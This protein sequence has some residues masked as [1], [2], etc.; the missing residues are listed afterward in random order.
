M[1]ILITGGTGLVGTR[2]TEILVKNG[3]RVSYLSRSTNTSS[4]I[5]I[6]KWDLD[7]N[8]IDPAAFE[9]IDCIVHLAGAGIADKR[10]SDDRKKEILESRIKPIEL[11]ANY[12]KN[13]SHTIKS[14]ISA[15]AIG[16]YGGDTG[17]TRIDETSAAGTDFLANVTKNWEAASRQIEVLGIRTVQIR[18]GI[19]LSNKGGAL[20]KLL[21]PIRLGFGA[22]LAG[23]KQFMS[24]IHI[25]D[26]CGIFQKAIETPNMHGAYNAVAPNPVT[27]Q[28]MTKVAAKILKKPLWLPSIPSFALHLLMGEMAIIATGGNYIL[29]KR[30]AEETDFKYEYMN[31][32][33]ALACEIG[34]VRL[35]R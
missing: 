33:K 15:S 30:I 24:W 27:N 26:L 10:W 7:K 18:V 29:N 8:Y 4:K 21:H 23:G 31:I 1:N 14:F 34:E 19:V 3:H 6:F 28:E 32:E 9:S 11:I 5:K 12:L 35:E 20:P 2:L 17:E 25:D 16:F 22:S 13:N